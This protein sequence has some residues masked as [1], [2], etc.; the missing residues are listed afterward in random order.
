LNDLEGPP[1][2][3]G[4]EEGMNSGCGLQ[5]EFKKLP[6]LPG[7]IYNS[8]Q[9]TKYE[10]CKSTFKARVWETVGYTANVFGIT[11]ISIF[12]NS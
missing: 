1:G 10:Q 8:Y 5:P 12:L 3:T 7:W 4:H 6:I 9:G 2:P 11:F